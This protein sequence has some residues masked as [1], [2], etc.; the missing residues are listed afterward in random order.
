ME[1]LNISSN[2]ENDSDTDTMAYM[3]NLHLEGG[4][5]GKGGSNSESVSHQPTRYD[6]TCPDEA[7]NATGDHFPKTRSELLEFVRLCYSNRDRIDRF[8]ELITPLDELLGKRTD[9]TWTCDSGP[10]YN[11]LVRQM[12]DIDI[13]VSSDMRRPSQYCTGDAVQT[14]SLHSIVTAVA[15]SFCEVMKDAM[16]EVKQEIKQLRTHPI[17][18]RSKSR[19]RTPV[20]SSNTEDEDGDDLISFSSRSEARTMR[21]RPQQSNVKLPVFNGK[22]SWKV[23]FTRFQLIAERSGWDDERKLSELIPKLQGIAG[24]FVFSELDE[25]VQRNYKQLVKELHFRFR[26]VENA[27]TFQSQFSHRD[28]RQ[29]ETVQEYAAELKRLYTKAHPE[30]D[31]NTRTEDLLRRFLDGVEDNKARFYVEYI[32]QPTDIDQA[33]F[34]VINFV[35]TRSSHSQLNDKRKHSARMVR[36][37]DS[38]DD[39]DDEDGQVYRIADQKTKAHSIVQK[40]HANKQVYGVNTTPESQTMSL[41]QGHVVQSRENHK[42]TRSC[43]NCGTVGHLSRDC[44]IPRRQRTPRQSMYTYSQPQS[45]PM[46][47]SNQQQQFYQPGNNPYPTMWMQNAPNQNQNT[48]MMPQYRQ[49]IPDCAVQE[50]ADGMKA[51]VQP[52]CPKI[53]EK[54]ASSA[55]FPKQSGLN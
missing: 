12:R 29:N 47:G 25:R 14:D 10:A 20:V 5:L 30:R 51:D 4:V 15:S 27:R 37:D 45:Y 9:F 44:T 23:W 46:Q 28:Q 42:E 52:F 54:P 13:G 34:E 19:Q 1:K 39:E 21:R 26:V 38:S 50:P 40:Q 55:L 48:Q 36:P 3:H 35:E 43:Y 11:H 8:E 18:V 7:T 17:D 32:K 41:S 53:H 24:D 33:A 16:K 6:Q 2:A 22:E 49:T 31:R